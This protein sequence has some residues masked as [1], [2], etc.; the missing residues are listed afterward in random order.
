[1]LPAIN[2]F[3]ENKVYGVYDKTILQEDERY[4][5]VPINVIDPKTANT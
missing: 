3:P 2:I 5:M 1:M 4:I